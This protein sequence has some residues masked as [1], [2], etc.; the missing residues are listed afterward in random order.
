MANKKTAICY[1]CDRERN[2]CKAASVDEEGN[3]VWVCPACWREF[4]YDRYLY[5]H[6]VKE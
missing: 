6:K 5:E 3:V 1:E 4:D 2:R